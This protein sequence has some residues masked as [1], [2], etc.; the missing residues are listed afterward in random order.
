MA[1]TLRCVNDNSHMFRQDGSMTPLPKPYLPAIPPTKYRKQSY[2]RYDMYIGII[3]KFE[4]V[5]I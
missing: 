1:A 5:L 3:Y 2:S 4:C